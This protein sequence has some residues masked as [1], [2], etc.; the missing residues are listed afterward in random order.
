[1]SKIVVFRQPFGY[2]FVEFDSED[3]ALRVLHRV[4]GKLVPGSSPVTFQAYFYFSSVFLTMF[5]NI[6]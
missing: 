2:G 4:N 1:M 3:V 6:N 5:D